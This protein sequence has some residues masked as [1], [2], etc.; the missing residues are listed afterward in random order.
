MS[1]GLTYK[2]AEDLLIKGFLLNET[3]NKE[4]IENILNKYW[5]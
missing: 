1:R 4:E 2:E 3:N 5:R